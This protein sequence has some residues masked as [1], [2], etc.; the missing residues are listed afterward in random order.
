MEDYFN[1]G[2]V[3]D[4]ASMVLSH[5]VRMA[6]NSTTRPMITGAM[7]EGLT[8]ERL[9]SPSQQVRNFLRIVGGEL[10]ASRSAFSITEATGASVGFASKDEQFRMLSALQEKGLIRKL[11]NRTRQR[12]HGGSVSEPT[13][14]LTLDGWDRYDEEQR[15]LV[16]GQYGFLAMKFGDRVLDRFVGEVLK[17]GVARELNY[18][19]LDMRDVPRAGIIDNIMRSQIRD[20]AFVL[21]DLTHDNSGAYWEA[22]YAEGLGKPVVYICERSKFET[23]KTHFDTNHCTTVPWTEDEPRRFVEELV[24]TLRRSLNLFPRAGSVA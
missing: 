18:Q 7:V 16:A 23:A 19:V 13:W 4:V 6:Q 12:A 14:D 10:Q 15:G 2:R 3:T 8:A 24:A 11:A 22:G 5:K 9:P 20:S 17:P 1:P 21:V